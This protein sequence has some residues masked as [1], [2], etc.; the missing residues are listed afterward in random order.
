MSNVTPVV[1]LAGGEGSRIGGS[2]PLR[3]L[4]GRTLIDRAVALAC[5]YSSTVAV[6]CRFSDQ[7]AISGARVIVDDPEVEGPLGGLLPALEFA[8][9][10]ARSEAL[11]IPADMPFLPRDL[12][13]RL[14]AAIGDK[15]AAVASSGGRMH[16]VCGLWRIGALDKAPL[17]L[18]TGK[19]SLKGFAEAIGYATAEWAPDPDPFFNINTADDLDA[20]ERRLTR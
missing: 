7:L 4:A 10:N 11:V 2:K 3:R 5:G 6:A 1:I 20:A 14:Q 18:R 12:L 15:L 19:R 17:Y 16:P 8:R 13:A 9:E